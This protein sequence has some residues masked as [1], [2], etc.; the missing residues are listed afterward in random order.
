MTAKSRIEDIECRIY[1]KY[2]KTVI[3]YNGMQDSIEMEAIERDNVL[4]YVTFVKSLKKI[5]LLA[6]AR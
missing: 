1:K 2:K 4:C 6:F 3:H 5:S